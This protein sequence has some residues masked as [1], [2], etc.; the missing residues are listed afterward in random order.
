MATNKWRAT[1]PL[2][3][4]AK[5]LLFSP[6]VD[7]PVT[8]KSRNLT[9]VKLIY[10][11]QQRDVGHGTL[12]LQMAML[13]RETKDLIALTNHKTLIYLKTKANLSRRRAFW[14]ETI[15]YYLMVSNKNIIKSSNSRTHSPE[16]TYILVFIMIV[17]I[18]TGH[19]L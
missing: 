10:H 3:S 4:L 11:Q 14:L 9:V 17:L 6:K 18:L 2:Q 19:I 8:Y 1:I 7:T 12:S 16:F 15:Y 5:C 13:L